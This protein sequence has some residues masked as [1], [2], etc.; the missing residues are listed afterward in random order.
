M[1]HIA[2][3]G[4]PASRAARR[5][6]L[7]LGRV[8]VGDVFVDVVLMVRRALRG[9]RDH[10]Q[11]RASGENDRQF[12]S[13]GNTLELRSSSVL[14]KGA[15]ACDEVDDQMREPH[16]VQHGRFGNASTLTARRA[17]N[18]SARRQRRPG[19]HSH[20]ARA[21]PTHSACPYRSRDA[22]ADRQIWRAAS[23]S[24]ARSGAL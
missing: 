12:P 1:P 17:P 10:G 14:K 15:G 5:G 9:P 3:Y 23:P 8:V 11:M 24:Q 2:V 19:L 22:S 13:A 21:H 18:L 7:G 4:S 6:T 20:S 16:R